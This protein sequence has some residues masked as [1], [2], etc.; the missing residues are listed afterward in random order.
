MTMNMQIGMTRLLIY[1]LK[2]FSLGQVRGFGSAIFSPPRTPIYQ[3]P[4]PST[5]N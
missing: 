2:N 5:P 4:E 1:Y 3:Q